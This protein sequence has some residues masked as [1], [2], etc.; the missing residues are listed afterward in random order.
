[1]VNGRTIKNGGGG[2]KFGQTV[3]SMKAAGKIISP[4]VKAD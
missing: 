4:M 3:Q 1:L 2:N